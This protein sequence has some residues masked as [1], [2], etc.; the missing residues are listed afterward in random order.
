MNWTKWNR[1]VH[2]WVS[3]IFIVTV[4]LATYAAATG[5]DQTSVL[6]YLPLLPL[7]ILMVSGTIMFVRHYVAK[8]RQ[9]QS[10]S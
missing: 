1:A 3:M 7:F 2:R 8:S 4:L 6:Y 10:A 9:T 5:T